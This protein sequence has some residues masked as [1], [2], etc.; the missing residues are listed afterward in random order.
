M[1]EA[2]Q[3]ELRIV[4]YIP[5]VRPIVSGFP[6]CSINISIQNNTKVLVVRNIIN[7]IDKYI[8]F[9]VLIKVASEAMFTSKNMAVNFLLPKYFNI[10]DVLDNSNKVNKEAIVY[11]RPTYFTPTLCAINVEF[12]YAEI[13]M[14]SVKINAS[15]YI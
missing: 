14:C 10:T 9:V 6:K 13:A 1:G 3:A 15:I 12:V 7:A 5:R 8:G 2:T 11:I 4:R